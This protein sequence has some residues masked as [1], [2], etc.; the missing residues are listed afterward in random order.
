ML[1]FM[2]CFVLVGGRHMSWFAVCYVHIW[3][4][5]RGYVL[6][7]LS[8]AAYVGL[9]AVMFYV[10]FLAAL[11]LSLIPTSCRCPFYVSPA[12]TTPGS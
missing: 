1:D 2:C 8:F 4:Y 9:L 5:E 12:S 11:C 3:V 7:C 10:A 6:C